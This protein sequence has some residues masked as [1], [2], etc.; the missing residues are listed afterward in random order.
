MFFF[1]FKQKTAY[2]IKECDWSSDVCSSDLL[3]RH[4][5]AVVARAAT[6]IT[7]HV[8]IGQKVH[9]DSL[10]AVTFACF[11][12]P[13]F[14]VEREATGFVTTFTRLRQHRIQLAQRREQTGVG[15]RIR[16]RR[17]ADWRLVDLDYFVDVFEPLD[18][19]VWPR[20]S[21]RTVEMLR[22]RVVKNVFN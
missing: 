5:L 21:R 4:R 1:F 17:A 19:L 9:L 12:T 18:S 2:E 14:D 11:T 22:E 6:H 13:A 20:L 10:H 15:R 7:E 16:T 8:H 3:H